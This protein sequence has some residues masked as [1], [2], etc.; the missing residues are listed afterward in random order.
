MKTSRPVATRTRLLANAA[1]GRARPVEPADRRIEDSVICSIQPSEQLASKRQ[2][3]HPSGQS[4]PERSH[5][6]GRAQPAEPE[7]RGIDTEVENFK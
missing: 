5:R 7:L 2:R 3:S 4:R 1:I 6:F